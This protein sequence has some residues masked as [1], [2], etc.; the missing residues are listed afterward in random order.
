MQKVPFTNEG[1][2]LKLEQ[3]YELSPAEFDAQ[4]DQLSDQC[5]A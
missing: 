4:M 3:L 5:D 1:L 2:Q